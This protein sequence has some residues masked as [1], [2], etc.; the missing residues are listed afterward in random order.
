MSDPLSVPCPHCGALNRVPAERL[1]EHPQCGRC[2]Q[3]LFEGKPVS[4]TTAQFDAVAMRGDLPVVVDFWASWCGPCRIFAPVFAEAAQRLEPQFRF[5]KVDT[6]AETTL[7]HRF[8][9]RSIPALLVLRDGKELARHVG[10]LKPME[11]RQFLVNAL[12]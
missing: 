7:A 3:S 4:L 1:A 12:K 9:I 11:L 8:I 6:E 2:K 5:A 10:A